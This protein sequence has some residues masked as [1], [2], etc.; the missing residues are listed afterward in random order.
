M[1][2]VPTIPVY[3]CHKKRKVE[4]FDSKS[5][6]YIYVSAKC[7]RGRNFTVCVAFVDDPHT[8]YIISGF[9]TEEEAQQEIDNIL[10]AIESG[11]QVYQCVGKFDKVNEQDAQTVGDYDSIKKWGE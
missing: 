4:A 9:D 8:G 1:L 5:I 10:T 11:K 7:F 3:T 6:S 2:I